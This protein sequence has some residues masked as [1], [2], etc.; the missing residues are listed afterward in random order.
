M[1]DTAPVSAEPV[2]AP[3]TPPA[4]QGAI[5]VAAGPGYAPDDGYTTSEGAKAARELFSGWLKAEGKEVPGE[6][7]P[8]EKP[9]PIIII[10]FF[11][12]LTKVINN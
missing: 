8:E 12:C 11:I 5:E 3:V 1:P 10:D 4:N 6:A 7:Q 9:E 2:A